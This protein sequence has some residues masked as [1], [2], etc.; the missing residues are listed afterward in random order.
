MWHILSLSSKE[1]TCEHDTMT[2][3]RI[4]LNCRSEYPLDSAFRDGRE[5]L[6]KRREPVQERK[7]CCGNMREASEGIVET[8]VINSKGHSIALKLEDERVC[9]G[10]FVYMIN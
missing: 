1:K 9:K 7:S 6:R 10:Q 3:S 8:Q 4:V 5:R 2:A